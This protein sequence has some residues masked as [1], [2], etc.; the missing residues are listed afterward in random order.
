[1]R[2]LVFFMFLLLIISCNNDKYYKKEIIGNWE[3]V[4]KPLVQN[5]H[6]DENDTLVSLVGIRMLMAHFNYSFFTNGTYIDRN[7]IFTSV[8]GEI[9]SDWKQYFLGSESKYS[10]ENKVLKIYD[11]KDKKYYEYQIVDLK[12]DTLRLTQKGED[13][14]YFKRKKYEIKCKD[15]FDKI[16]ISSTGCYGTCPI[17]DILIDKQGTFV[18]DGIKY[19]TVEGLNT[20]K[21]NSNKFSIILASFQKANWKNLKDYYHAN[22]TDSETVTVSF[23]KKSKIVKTIC[24]YGY[25][26]P[27]EF[28]WAYGPLREMYQRLELEKIKYQPANLAFFNV[29]KG[30]KWMSLNNSV[31]FYLKYL[32]MNSKISNKEC[33]NVY[34]INTLNLETNKEIHVISDGQLFKFELEKGKYITFDLGYNFFKFNNLENGFISRTN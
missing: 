8:K 32:L 5:R 21:M 16:V 26:S 4:E 18:F 10:I 15:D 22:F 12:N 33:D 2:N 13:T 17:G 34:Q 24:D 31:G 28:R 1:M 29:F 30:N 20:A 25:E 27:L 14:L 9:Y 7:G 6:V 23:I 11:S 19:N 3:E